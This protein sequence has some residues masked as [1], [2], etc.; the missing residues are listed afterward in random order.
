MVSAVL[1]ASLE[2]VEVRPDWLCE[3]LDVVCEVLE[4]APLEL[5]EGG[6]G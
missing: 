6:L 5:V 3:T 1:E 2:L 4:V